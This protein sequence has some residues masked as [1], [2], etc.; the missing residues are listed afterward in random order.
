MFP[1]SQ[2][3]EAM[4]TLSTFLDQQQCNFRELRSELLSLEESIT[5]LCIQESHQTRRDSKFSH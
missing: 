4:A 2:A 3:H 5:L 1:C